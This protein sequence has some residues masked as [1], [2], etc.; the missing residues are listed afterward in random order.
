MDKEKLE[1]LINKFFLKQ[2]TLGEKVLFEDILK[3]SDEARKLF[4][5]WSFIHRGVETIQ[6]NKTCTPPEFNITLKEKTNR[7]R[8]WRQRV[9]N[10]AAVL[11]IPLLIGFLYLFVGKESLSKQISHELSYTNT[12]SKAILITLPDSS[13]VYLYAKS[14]L[15]YPSVFTENE[16][17]VKLTGEATFEVV[18][19]PENPFY[20]ET[21]DGVKVKA[22]G[23]KF[24]VYGYEDDDIMQVYLERGKVNFSSPDLSEPTVMRASTKLEFNRKSKSIQILPSDA[25]EYEAYEKGILLFRS[26]SL[27]RI[28]KKLSRVY[29]VD[30]EIRD[31]LLCYYPITGVF[32]NKTITQILDVLQ[33]SSPD[34]KWKKEKEKIILYRKP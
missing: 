18:S 3:S 34:L 15:R 20:V 6:F 26:T 31:S 2:L 11:T 19:D 22:Y 16:R 27:E 7:V 24:N 23:T 5:Q 32:E 13:R 10:I 21:L 14:T 17:H 25:F 12:N 30:I 29:D 9:I 8:L 1:D 4:R 28:T 33:M